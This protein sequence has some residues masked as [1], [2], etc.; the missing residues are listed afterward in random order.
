MNL[1]KN[2]NPVFEGLEIIGFDLYSN[3]KKIGFVKD[4]RQVYPETLTKEPIEVLQGI[5]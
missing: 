2:L 1:Y 4:D 3:S 5:G